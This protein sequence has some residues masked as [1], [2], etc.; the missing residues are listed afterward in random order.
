MAVA[1][2]PKLVRVGIFVLGKLACIAAVGFAYFAGVRALEA[3][4]FELPPLPEEINPTEIAPKEALPPDAAYKLVLGRGLFKGA[5]PVDPN[6][7]TVTQPAT[8]KLK[9]VATYIA[10]KQNPYA[11]IEDSI[12]REQGVFELRRGGQSNAGD[13]IFN[14][15]ELIDVKA[16]SAT[17]KVLATGKLEVLRLEDDKGKPTGGTDAVAMNEEAPN[18]DQTQFTLSEA[19]VSDALSNLP[20]L[21]S[22]ARAVP[23]FRNGQSV[24]MRLFA[25]RKDSLYEKIGL[26]NGDIIKSVND[27]SVS[28][29]TQALK[30]FEQ[31]KSERSLFVNVERSGKDMR[32]DYTVR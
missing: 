11:I 32:L 22:Q 27:T 10:D 15:A 13:L 1:L 14:Q 20:L 16:D 28:D 3:S 24:G 12:K 31:L 26:K 2:N 18:D 21:L 29:P 4:Q 6:A 17:I 30:I 23:Y 7:Q 5:V 25:I 8:V 9:L 19:E